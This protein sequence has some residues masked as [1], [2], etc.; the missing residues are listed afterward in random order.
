M[1]QKQRAIGDLPHG[2]C[3]LLTSLRAFRRV[4]IM[5]HQVWITI[6]PANAADQVR[7]LFSVLP[8]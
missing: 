8:P 7:K 4:G 5:N 6:E 2:E 1:T 3:G